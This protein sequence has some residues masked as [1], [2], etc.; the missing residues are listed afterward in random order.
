MIALNQYKT[1][2]TAR[3]AMMFTG[4]S[5]SVVTVLIDNVDVTSN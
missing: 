3:Q 5:R 2:S 4:A 1:L